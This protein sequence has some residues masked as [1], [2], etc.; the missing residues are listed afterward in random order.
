[1]TQICLADS[2]TDVEQAKTKYLP[3]MVRQKLALEAIINGQPFC[4]P[5]ITFLG[6]HVLGG[7]VVENWFHHSWIGGEALEAAVLILKRD[8]E[9]SLAMLRAKATSYGIDLDA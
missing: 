5:K 4:E 3:M 9:A 6:K 1:M 8:A 2:G 7:V